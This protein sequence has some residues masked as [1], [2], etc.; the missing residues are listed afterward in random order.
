[1]KQLL[2]LIG[3]RLQLSASTSLDPGDHDV[4]SDSIQPASKR[5]VRM[6]GIPLI[7]DFGEVHE[8]F[9]RRVDGVR[10]LQAHSLRDAQ[11]HRF[12]DPYEFLP[13]CLVLNVL[14]AG[15]QAVSCWR[16]ERHHSSPSYQ[17]N[18]QISRDLT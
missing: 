2:G 7:D 1:M 13:G 6:L 14:Q 11:Q 16:I 10:F 18:S 12:V 8:H 5:T 17:L 15:D 9:L 4:A 3:S